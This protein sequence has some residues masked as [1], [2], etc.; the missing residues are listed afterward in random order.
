MVISPDWANGGAAKA[1]AVTWCSGTA[2]RT[3]VVS[4]ANSLVGAQAND[5]IGIGVDYFGKLWVQNNGNY[6]VSSPS[7]TANAGAVTWC[8]GTAGCTGVVSAANSLVGTQPENYV[9]GG[10]ITEGVLMLPNGDCVVSSPNWSTGS[11]ANAGAVTWCGGTTGCT[12]AV[13]AA[14]SLVGGAAGDQVGYNGIYPL[15]QGDYVVLS[16]NW[17]NNGTVDSGAV[18]RGTVRAVRLPGF[19]PPRTACAEQRLPP[20]ALP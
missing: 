9:G 7:W 14:N 16:F 20:G 5:Q 3:G 17:D 10:Q 6:V 8:S 2:G 19:S 15:S 12:G 1:G 11:A 18:T 13:S 4:A